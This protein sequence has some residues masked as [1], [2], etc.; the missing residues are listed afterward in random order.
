MKYSMNPV[1]H[2]GIETQ[3]EITKAGTCLSFQV[4]SKDMPN[5][6]IVELLTDIRF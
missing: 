4:C 5:S 3:L 1:R 2:Y 6:F